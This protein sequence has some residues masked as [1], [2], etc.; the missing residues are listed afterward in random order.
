MVTGSCSGRVL[1][2]VLMSTSHWALVLCDASFSH[3]VLKY[4][5]VSR[6]GGSNPLLLPPTLR[7][8][9]GWYSGKWLIYS[10]D[11]PLFGL[12]HQA[13]GQD[14][15][16]LINNLWPQVWTAC[17][18]SVVALSCYCL[19]EFMRSSFFRASLILRSIICLHDIVLCGYSPF[20]SQGSL[21]LCCVSS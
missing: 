12:P 10:P 5:S 14:S 18:T 9:R 6:L 17:C 13:G 20:Y 7:V 16:S 15:E 4:R 19:S 11:F 21:L 8:Y 2:A 1:W 3:M